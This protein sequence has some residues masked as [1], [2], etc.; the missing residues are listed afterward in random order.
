[1]DTLSWYSEED[2]KKFSDAREHNESLKLPYKIQPQNQGKLV[3]LSGAPGAGKSTT[4][5]YLSKKAD[6]VY[7][8]GDCA[9][10]MMN[11]FIHPKL[12]GN[13]A[14]LSGQQEPIKVLL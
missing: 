13:P 5:H 8:E 7:Y 6:F 14:L 4:G 10:G 3:W 2:V 11:P 12:E 9:M 1:M